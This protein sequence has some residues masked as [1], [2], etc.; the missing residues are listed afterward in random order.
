MLLI[1]ATSLLIMNNTNC[2]YKLW[3]TLTLHRWFDW[4]RNTELL[5][6]LGS[7][8]TADHEEIDKNQILNGLAVREL[9]FHFGGKR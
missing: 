3:C 6:Q 9:E 4:F 7:E 1:G 5:V 2:T 8:V